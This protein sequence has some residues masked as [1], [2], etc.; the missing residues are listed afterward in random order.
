[1]NQKKNRGFTLIELLAVIVIL[2]IIAVIAVPTVKNIT[3]DAKMKAFANTARGIVRAG[4]LYYSRKDMMDEINGDATFNFSNDVSELQINGKLPEAG[5]MVINEDGDVALAISNGKYCAVKG[6]SD[7]DVSVIED[8]ENC[9]IPVTYNIGD[10]IYYNPETNE[11]C[12]DYVEANSEESNTS[13]CLK[14]YVYNANGSKAKLM[15]DHDIGLD[16]YG[17][18]FHAS[19]FDANPTIASHTLVSENLLQNKVSNWKALANVIYAEDVISSTSWYKELSDKSNWIDKYMEVIN[20]VESNISWEDYETEEE[21]MNAIVTALNKSGIILPKFLLDIK[22]M[23]EPLIFTFDEEFIFPIINSKIIGISS[24]EISFYRYVCPSIEIN[25]NKVLLKEEQNITIQAI[26]FQES[27]QGE[28]L[29][30]DNI[31]RYMLVEPGNANR[32][33]IQFTIDGSDVFSINQFGYI[34][35]PNCNTDTVTITATTTD[36]SNIVET[37]SFRPGGCPS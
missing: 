34:S 4:D 29:N 32:N 14:W 16:Y 36:G 37:L 22:T 8:L 27:V 18:S 20:N 5:T 33:K 17:N 30:G 3:K 25:N 7:K 2:G 9:L 15:L 6:F 13:G 28:P 21:Y 1:M 12:T 24:G 31:Y 10:I 11:I 26:H 35:Y 23:S 19:Y